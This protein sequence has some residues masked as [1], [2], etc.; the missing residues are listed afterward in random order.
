[1]VTICVHVSTAD[2]LHLVTVTFTYEIADKTCDL[3]VL[4]F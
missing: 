4:H 3:Y 2:L 1:M